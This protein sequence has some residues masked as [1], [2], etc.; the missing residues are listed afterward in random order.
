MAESQQRLNA[1]HH[2]SDKKPGLSGLTLV[3]CG[4]A[5]L[6]I[7]FQ[8][9]SLQALVVSSSPPPHSTLCIP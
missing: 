2:L 6:C 3:F 7:F 9:L 8:F 1:E 5:L 4:L